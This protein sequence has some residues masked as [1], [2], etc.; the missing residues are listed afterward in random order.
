MVCS[1]RRSG[2]HGVWLRSGRRQRGSSDA[3]ILDKVYTR[4]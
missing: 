1:L 2:W 3:A 4:V